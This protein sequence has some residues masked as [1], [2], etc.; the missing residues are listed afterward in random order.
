MPVLSSVRAEG[1]DTK[2]VAVDDAEVETL[3][4]AAAAG[5]EAAWQRL[6]TAIKAPLAKIV[7]QP[8][9]LGK[10]G[11]RED[12]RDNIVVA[13]LERLRAENFRRLGIY[14]E[15]R[16][17]NPNLKFM[18]WLRVVA[19]RVGIDYLRGHQDYIRNYD[20]DASKPG[21]LVEART[22]PPPSQLYG[23][24]PPITVLGT[25]HE[26][27][28]K[29]AEILAPDQLAAVKLWIHSESYDDI[30]KAMSLPSARDA[31]RI[32]RAALERMRRN[33]RDPDPEEDKS[34]S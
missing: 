8:R 25:A 32:V 30:A 28:F 33:L 22:L 1:H 12:D 31:E 23:I 4:S 7:A 2:E 29:A 27:L 19:K 17:A 14:L 5:D 34:T 3:V 15:A 18:S 21:E 20:A 11:R 24:R 13:V 16:R 6:M 9:F 10:L 26:L